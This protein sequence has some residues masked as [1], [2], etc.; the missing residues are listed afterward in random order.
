MDRQ[1][2]SCVTLRN[3]GAGPLFNAGDDHSHLIR[4]DTKTFVR[5]NHGNAK[6]VGASNKAKRLK[7]GDKKSKTQQPRRDAESIPNTTTT[8]S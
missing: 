1:S 4:I 2:P 3:S 5:T 8:V 7:K 6:K